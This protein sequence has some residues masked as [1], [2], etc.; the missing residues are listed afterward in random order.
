[1]VICR[2][3]SSQ[4][5]FYVHETCGWMTLR[6][7]FSL[8]PFPRYFRVFFFW[9]GFET[10]LSSQKFTLP[11]QKH[12]RLFASKLKVWTYE[13]FGQIS[14]ESPDKQNIKVVRAR[15]TLIS[16]GYICSWKGCKYTILNFIIRISK[17][18]AD[19]GT[20]RKLAV[21]CDVKISKAVVTLDFVPFLRKE[22]E[23]KGIFNQNA[24][25]L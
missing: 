25:N 2:E 8:S 22:E 21:R 11:A 4:W 5:N 20:I 16:I 3:S 1:M 13:Q 23:V 7:T 24:L 9:F 14:L 10:W 6:Y 19:P 17:H 15:W 18:E 12:E